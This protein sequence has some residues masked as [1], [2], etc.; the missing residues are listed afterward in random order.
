MLP[1]D[2]KGARTIF[3]RNNTIAIAMPKESTMQSSCR[4]TIMIACYRKNRWFAETLDSL[5]NS[6]YHF[7][8][9]EILICDDGA[10]AGGDGDVAEAYAARH[11][12]LF[13][14]L[15][16]GV[17]KG[18]A[19]THNR[20]VREAHGK[21]I[22]AFD[23]DDIFVPFDIDANLDFLDQH[24]EYAATFGKKHLFSAERG[25]WGEVHG[26]DYS[27]FAMLGC[28]M[29][30]HNGMITRASDIRPEWAYRLPSGKQCQAA[31]DISLWLGLG[32]QK[33]LFFT[34]EVR[35]LF[36]IHDKQITSTSTEKYRQDYALLRE[37]L[38]SLYPELVKKAQSHGN[39][40]VT[41]EEVL[42]F[43]IVCGVLFAL[44]QTQVERYY[45][46]YIAEMAMPEDYVI[47][48]YRCS[49][50]HEEQRYPEELAELFRISVK[51]QDS[52][53]IQVDV[54]NRA[55]ACMEKMGIDTTGL[56]KELGHR[57]GVF[58]ALSPQ[59]ADLLRTAITNAQTFDIENK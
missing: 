36:R 57:A 43:T 26:G 16:N 27:T 46:L 21:Y 34:N 55:I 28:P 37:E 48:E 15:H 54:L 52:H 17:N 42:P 10:P 45:Y 20:L 13:R 3:I 59:Q 39:F 53:Y 31:F 9:T 5:L 51:H 35:A 30:T 32:L 8:D 24:P 4:L 25:Y 40:Q 23:C 50:L 44:A 47:A 19:Y 22:L 18:G 11:P 1:I 58:Y 38:L 29:V 33:K 56:R 41:A 14:V 12:G 6:G 2:N 49:L 7:R